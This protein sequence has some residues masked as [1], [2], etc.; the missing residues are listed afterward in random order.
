MRKLLLVS[1]I[2][3][4][5]I[6]YISRLFYLQIYT[7]KPYNIFED[8]AIRKVYDYPKRGNV[9]DRNGKLLVAN[10]ASYDVMVIPR[11]VEP[12]DTLEFCSLLKITKEDFIKIYNKSKNYSPRLP[13]VFVSH[14]SKED[15]AILQEKMR[16]FDGFYIQKRSLRDYQTT[17]GANV[18]GDIGEVSRSLINKEP[19]YKMGDLIGKQGV[20]ISY[21]N[22]LRGVKGIKF[23]Q[24][25]RF[26]RDIGPY[27]EGKFD[28]IAQAGKDITITIDAILQEYGEKLMQNKRGGIIALE[29]SSG[30]ILAMITAPS[31]N[32]NKLV[33]RER[34]KNFTKLYR[35]TIAKPLFDRGLKAQYAPGSPFK[36][37][38]ALIA[39]QEDVVNTQENFTCRMGYYYGS[40]KLTGC[41]HHR[42]PVNMNSGIYMSCN[43]Y[44]ANVFRRIID[45]Y[46]SPDK[47]TNKWSNHVKSFGLG[48]YLGYDL[49]IGNKGRI[50]DGNFYNKWYPD[51]KWGSPTI[52]SNA[53]GQGEVETTPIQL[54]NMAAAIA[55][56]GFFYT[57]HIIKHIKNDTIDRKFTTPKYTTIDKQYFEPVIQGMLDVF[58]KPGGTANYLKVPGIEICGK[59]GTAENFIKIDSVRTQ[60]TDHSIFVAFAPKDNPKIAI[61]VFVE[62][63][64]WGSRYAGRIASL[65]IEKY[66]K[67][68]ITRIDLERWIIEHTLE[69]EYN[70]PYS[71]KPFKIN[72]ETEILRI[73]DYK[74]IKRLEEQSKIKLQTVNNLQQ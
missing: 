70:K 14:L 74:R 29:P 23:I 32:P 61:A 34:S 55:N 15:Y 12:L 33:G 6:I 25:N 60:L 52:I 57:P 17:I 37:L 73:E 3:I 72:G 4:T 1:L 38:N 49:K 66:I 48:N 9:Y 41:H 62:N 71:G 50:P 21:E 54:A 30:E 53:I 43:A 13:S 27:K 22:T 18:L 26:N 69:N 58:E 56:R 40:K 44:F 20:E 11:E 67:K 64:Y 19:Y 42:S 65:M 46:D 24:K 36:V 2:I 39:L 31:Y 10:Q 45:K 8:N 51:F 47:G 59:T 68:E 16:K 28:T 63:G 35:D 7:G 5:G